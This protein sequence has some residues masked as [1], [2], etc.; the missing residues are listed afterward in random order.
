MLFYSSN[1]M[2][3][4]HQQLDKIPYPSIKKNEIMPCAAPWMELERI[5]L[6]ETIQKEKQKCHMVSVMYG[7]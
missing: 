4:L 5:T 2:D 7:L 1:L 6:S 3:V